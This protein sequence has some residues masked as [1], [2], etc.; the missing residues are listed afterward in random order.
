MSKKLFSAEGA[1]FEIFLHNHTQY[2]LI[3]DKDGLLVLRVS[4]DRPMLL[5]Y[6]LDLK[7]LPSALYCMDLYVMYFCSKQSHKSLSFFEVIGF[8]TSK[9]LD[10]KTR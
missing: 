5:D 8:I 7:M 6:T 10:F 4:N 1:V 3:V 9:K 2:P